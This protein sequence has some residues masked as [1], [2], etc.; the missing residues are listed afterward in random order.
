MNRIGGWGD[1][2]RLKTDPSQGWAERAGH[3]R[4]SGWEKK[5]KQRVLAPR[6][7]G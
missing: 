2:K 3:P 5:G 1:R 4:R 6:L 7:G